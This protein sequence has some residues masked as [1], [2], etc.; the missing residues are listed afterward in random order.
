M[1]VFFLIASCAECLQIS[2]LTGWA[3]LNWLQSVT[4]CYF[5]NVGGRRGDGCEPTATVHCSPVFAL[6]L[7]L[8]RC[9]PAKNC[10]RWGQF[11]LRCLLSLRLL[12]R[13]SGIFAHLI[14]HISRK[15]LPPRFGS[16]WRRRFCGPLCGAH[17]FVKEC[18]FDV[19]IN[20]H[21]TCSC[22]CKYMIPL[23]YFS[24]GSFLT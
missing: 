7:R 2:M 17:D 14:G 22:G 12:V 8:W 13:I 11:L 5:R 21:C 10:P 6:Q 19:E 20:T 23:K 1:G 9:E 4:G 16:E 15:S 3:A 24:V 18:H